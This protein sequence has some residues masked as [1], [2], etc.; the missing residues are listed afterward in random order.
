MGQ[1]IIGK[2]REI[3]NEVEEDY[4]N[5]AKPKHIYNTLKQIVENYSSDPMHSSLTGELRN[6]GV[7]E[8]CKQ[9]EKLQK[10]LTFQNNY[11]I[12]YSKK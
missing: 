3:V 6:E 4:R 2:L 5:M 8:I 10:E 7:K 1:E 9:L 11:K 12:E